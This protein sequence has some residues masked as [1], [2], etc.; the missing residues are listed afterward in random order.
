[1]NI[2]VGNK[3]GKPVISITISNKP[4]CRFCLSCNYLSCESIFF[5]SLHLPREKTIPNNYHFLAYFP[6]LPELLR[7]PLVSCGI[8]AARSAVFCVM[9]CRSLFVIFL[10]AMLLS[11]LLITPLRSSKFSYCRI[12]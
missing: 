5:K 12:S 7:S 1:M 2:C 6:T 8:C 3:G 10:L 4:R 11:V 9:F